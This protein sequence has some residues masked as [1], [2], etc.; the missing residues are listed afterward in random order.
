MSLS[1]CGGPADEQGFICPRA[2]R[3]LRV[4]QAQSGRWDCLDQLEDEPR[5][6]ETIHVYEQTWQGHGAFVCP[7]GYSAS[8]TY[9]HIV[10]CRFRGE[11]D[12]VIRARGSW[13]RFVA[14]YFGI[15]VD[16]STGE[17]IAD[18]IPINTGAVEGGEPE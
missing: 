2:P 7:G 3:L 8:A 9:R 17:Q 14:A 18:V 16:P 15:T 4:V 5:P 12:R 6:T 11:L 1:L 10:S 13:R